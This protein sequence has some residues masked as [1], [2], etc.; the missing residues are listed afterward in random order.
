MLFNVPIEPIRALNPSQ[1]SKRT[2]LLWDGYIGQD[3]RRSRTARGVT[4]LTR[5]SVAL[6]K[7]KQSHPHNPSR[8]QYFK[9][10]EDEPH[11]PA[12]THLVGPPSTHQW[13]A[14]LYARA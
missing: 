1:L 8:V 13:P 6:S 11:R 10:A 9:Q 7:V 3:P 4:T 14:R 2:A 5:K 12:Q